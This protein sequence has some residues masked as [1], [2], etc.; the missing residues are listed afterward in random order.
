MRRMNGPG[1][2]GMS[3]P[4]EERIARMAVENLGDDE[5][6][7]FRQN[8]SR[9]WRETRGKRD[10]IDQARTEVMEVL[11]ANELDE[12]AAKAAFAKLRDAEM[13]IRTQLHSGLIGLMKDLPVEKRQE[14]LKRSQERFGHR[15]DKRG[16][17]HEGRE[18]R[19]GGP[20]SRR[21]EDMPPPPDDLL[22]SDESETPEPDQQ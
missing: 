17:H 3:G 1:G 10:A 2:G 19:R 20:D 11:G 16:D 7:E 6:R 8:L 12:A 14:I 22:P 4:F 9:E 21:F 5:R 13:G 18:D 15:G